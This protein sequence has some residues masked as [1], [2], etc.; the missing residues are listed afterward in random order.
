M[1]SSTGQQPSR[2]VVNAFRSLAL[3]STIAVFWNMYPQM[4]LTTARNAIQLAET[5]SK[6]LKISGVKRINAQ[7]KSGQKNRSMLIENGAM[8]ALLEC[9]RN[10]DE[11]LRELALEGIGYLMKEESVEV[12][13]EMK[14]LV[15]GM[16]CDSACERFWRAWGRD[17]KEEMNRW[18]KMATISDG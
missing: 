11:N 8:D 2:L 10:E 13:E 7:A 16:K 9:T 15:G 17:R 3:G 5:E 6:T 1:A 14:V 18:S 12:N 4:K